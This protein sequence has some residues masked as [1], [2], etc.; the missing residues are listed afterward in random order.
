MTDQ[1]LDLSVSVVLDSNGNGVVSLGPQIVRE[2]WQ[3]VSVNVSASTT[4]KEAVC[5]LYLGSSL[6]AAQAL[7][8]T[9]TGSSGDTCPMSGIDMQA[10]RQII[11]QWIGGD[12]GAQA[13]MRVIGTK[14][15]PS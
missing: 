4:V 12:P 14:S 13:T 1:Q 9:A 15:R 5:T 6:I 8:E 3:P 2:R 11:A 10:G 7:S